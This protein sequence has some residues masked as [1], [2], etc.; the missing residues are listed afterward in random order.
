MDNMKNKIISKLNYFKITNHIIKKRFF[1]IKIKEGFSL[2]NPFV[3]IYTMGKVGSSSIYYSLKNDNQVENVFHLHFATKNINIHK[4][5]SKK[6]GDFPYFEHLYIGE[7]IANLNLIETNKK[8]EIITLVRDPIAIVVSN[9]F[10]NPKIT[11]SSIFNTEGNIDFNL[12]K[13]Y[14]INELKK[15]TIFD[16]F[17]DWFNE[18]LKNFTGIDVF[19]TSF[20]KKKGSQIIVKKNFKVLFLTLENLNNNYSVICDFL[21]KKN[22]MFNRYNERDTSVN[23]KIYKEIVNS[24]KLPREL[25][26]EIYNRPI[27]NHFYNEEQVELFIKKWSK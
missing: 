26:L 24:I 18:E 11:S 14:L 8:V 20:D 15:G 3:L 10:Q 19:D 7:Q 12:A 22:L 6:I 13:N 17:D 5:F 21:G 23:A 4:K 2:K 1:K 25:L 16:F 9:L 27:V